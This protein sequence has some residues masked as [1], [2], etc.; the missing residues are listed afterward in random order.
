MSLPPP[1][2][3]Q[4][5]AISGYLTGGEAPTKRRCTNMT[6]TIPQSYLGI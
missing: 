4:V 6:T 5:V 3:G 1:G 2:D